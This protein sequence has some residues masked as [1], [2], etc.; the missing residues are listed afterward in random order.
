MAFDGGDDWLVLDDTSGVLE[1]ATLLA[2]ARPST[3][4]VNPQVRWHR[5]LVDSLPRENRPR[6]IEAGPAAKPV[7]SSIAARRSTE[8]ASADERDSHRRT[9]PTGRGRRE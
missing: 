1:A 7:A 3:V 9:G 5:E 6:V 4:V 8:T 2:A